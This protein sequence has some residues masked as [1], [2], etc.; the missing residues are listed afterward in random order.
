MVILVLV[1]IFSCR[2]TQQQVNKQQ[3]MEEI[4]VQ[5]LAELR[6][7]KYGNI[8]GALPRLR[9]MM[10]GKF[11]HQTLVKVAVEGEEEKIEKVYRTWH[12]KD[13]EDSMM[14]YQ[15]PVGNHHK[16]GYWMYS[17]QYLTSLPKEPVYQ[18]LF[19]LEVINRDTI[20]ATYYE[21]PE[22]LKLDFKQNITALKT[23]LEDIEWKKLKLYNGGAVKH[24]E[25]QSILKYNGQSSMKTREVKGYEH[26]KYAIDYTIV[27]PGGLVFGSNYYDKD[28]K[29]SGG[30]SPDR[31]LKLAGA[32][33]SL[34]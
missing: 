25:R 28:K 3:N 31:L 29:S 20:K 26:I 4:F 16:I 22:D 8:Q 17:C 1:S 15:I 7:E 23:S 18:T 19:K 5:E 14:V 33:P 24:F 34:Y 32:N 9:A 13:G 12:T 11:V 6:Q 21:V 27:E 10:S 2:T 30:N